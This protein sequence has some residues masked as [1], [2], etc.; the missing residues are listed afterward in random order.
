MGGKM[1]LPSGWIVSEET[2]EQPL[3]QPSQV[4]E[5]PKN[6]LAEGWTVDED[7][8]TETTP[9][10]RDLA[11]FQKAAGIFAPQEKTSAEIKAMSFD[12]LMEYKDSL[13]YYRENYGNDA[14]NNEFIKGNLS[15]LTFGL[16]E[17]I[18]GL[19]PEE[20]ETV[21]N[22]ASIAGK[23]TGSLLP[24]SKMAKVIEGPAMKLATKSPIFQKQLG[25]LLTMMGVGTA[26]QG[27][28]TLAKGQMPSADEM[29]EHGLEWA[30]LD[31]ALQ[32]AGVVGKGLY[33]GAKYA[34][35]FTK[36]LLTKTAETAI[37]AKDLL[38]TVTK[39][40]KDTGLNKASSEEVSEAA[41]DILRGIEANPEAK[42]Q[43]LK[44]AKKEAGQVEK[45][46]EQ[47]LKERTVTPKD[48]KDRKVTNNSLQRLEQ[49][50]SVLAEPIQPEKVDFRKEV[51]D[52]ER[53]GVMSKLEIVSERSGSKEEL[54]TAIREDITAQ[55]KT[56][57]AAYKPLYEAAEE[58]AQYIP[59]HATETA[60][61]AFKTLKEIGSHKTNPEGYKGVIQSLKEI[62]H[63]AGYKVEKT[64]Q[65]AQ[66]LVKDTKRSV[67]V[68]HTMELAKRIHKKIKYDQLE[69]GVKDNLRDVVKAAKND[70]RTG[71]K[72]HPEALKAFN[73]AEAEHARVA[74][75]Y[76]TDAVKKVRST[77]AGE[78]IAKTIDNPTVLKDLQKTMSPKEYAKVQRE[79][80]ENLR[81]MD[82]LKSEKHLREVNKYLSK[83]NQQLAKELVEAKNPHNPLS[84]QKAVQEAIYSDLSK[85]V[86]EGT[87]PSKTLNLW[88][89][90]K[91]QREVRRA[92]KGSPNE[93]E[94]IQYLEK[95]SYNDMVSSVMKDG[96]IDPKKIGQFM[97]DPAM[98]NN[99]LEIGGEDALQFMY[100]METK[101][102][103]LRENAKL[104]E[105][106][107]TAGEA[108]R[109][110]QMLERA[111]ERNTQK[112]K[113]YEKGQEA[114]R[115]NKTA[116]EKADFKENEQGKLK[117]GQEILGR[118][119]KKDHPYQTK[120]KEW[121]AWGKE[122]LG[123]NE[124]AA[125]TI[126]GAAK[127]GAPIWGPVAFGVGISNTVATMFGMKFMN[128]LLTNPR[129]RNE[130][131]KM[132]RKGID[133]TAM[134]LY[135]HN[136]G[137]SVEEN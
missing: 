114:L 29:L 56:E 97:K 68:K 121:T 126:F 131:L 59:H 125:M 86:T 103:Q 9:E 135:L 128:K 71:L 7:K 98:V 30:A 137:E 20:Y 35:V 90:K 25:S 61:T 73:K 108:K 101:L 18:P 75:K 26:T 64:A 54:G 82:Y 91:G 109:G 105:R 52:M 94:M 106:L 4:K 48:L 134:M 34:S 24:L 70:V 104:L 85:A 2:E 45:A 74:Q 10:Q 62:I 111:A 11:K 3:E 77:E 32:A 118:M 78:T 50:S 113:T 102:G 123:L 130:F 83:E 116:K 93:K 58:Q 36:E 13:K 41:L 21:A 112:S 79:V 65:G 76:G 120:I 16:T 99:I 87:R 23:L 132:S 51:S 80:L 63:D 60:E 89:T 14:A 53:A 72:E 43:A 55:R 57:K 107:P 27:L 28:E 38:K 12:E 39:G 81:E 17:N 31:A 84:R 136:F 47:A 69:Y 88:Q 133:P 22:Q 8:P 44:V 19:K 95:Q 96:V 42:A 33:V 92:L 127:L 129:S 5:R 6:G 124:Q 37:P 1:T 66:R 15:G 119:A 122:M 100:K 46:A 40:L 110:Q 67:P 117:R 49:E 115:P